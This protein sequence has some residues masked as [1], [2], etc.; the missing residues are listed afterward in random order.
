MSKYKIGSVLEWR[1][2]GGET[3]HAAVIHIE[4]RDG[5]EVLWFLDTVLLDG[6]PD[7]GFIVA[8]SYAIRLVSE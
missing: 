1:M 8:D 3:L 4:I 2:P 6:K 7:Y 5:E